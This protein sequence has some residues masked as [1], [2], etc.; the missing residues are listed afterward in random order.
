MKNKPLEL[1]R[2][3]KY[4][5]TLYLKMFYYCLIWSIVNLINQTKILGLIEL[6]Q[7]TLT[8][9]LLLTISKLSAPFLCRNGQTKRYW[10]SCIA[11]RDVGLNPTCDVLLYTA[12]WRKIDVKMCHRKIVDS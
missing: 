10:L 3:S 11:V 8:M 12:R 7:E 2:K 9:I 5:L 1:Q 4:F 6:S